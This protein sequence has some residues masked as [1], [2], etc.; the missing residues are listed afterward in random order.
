MIC[1][2]KGTVELPKKVAKADNMISGR[3]CSMSIT[4][5]GERM[6]R[7]AQM[8]MGRHK[9]PAFEILREKYPF[10]VKGYVCEPEA[11]YIVIATVVYSGSTR[12]TVAKDYFKHM[13]RLK[14]HVMI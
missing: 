7:E 9:I 3:K 10:R 1:N 8:K 12:G 2:R 11:F 4:L 6:W 5:V 13:A 14:L